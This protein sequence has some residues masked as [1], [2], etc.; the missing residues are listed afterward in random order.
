MHTSGSIRSTVTKFITDNN[1][2]VTNLSHHQQRQ[3][4]RPPC[5]LR[6]TSPVRHL[7]QRQRADRQV[8]A[9]KNGLTTLYPR[10]S[11]DGFTVSSGGLNRSVTIAAG[12]D[13]APPRW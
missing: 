12:A 11:G 6:A 3:R 10:L 13:R 4:A 7:R 5:T 2:A 9:C 8:N 1:V